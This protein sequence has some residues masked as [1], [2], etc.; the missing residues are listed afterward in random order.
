MTN[1]LTAAIKF[2]QPNITGFLPPLTLR[3]NR[4]DPQSLGEVSD[5]EIE[6]RLRELTKEINEIKKASPEKQLTRG[7]WLKLFERH[8]TAHCIQTASYVCSSL[9]ELEGNPEIAVLLPQRIIILVHDG[10]QLNLLSDVLEGKKEPSVLKL[11]HMFNAVNL[12]DRLKQE[13]YISR[14][15][16]PTFRELENLLGDTIAIDGTKESQ[17]QITTLASALRLLGDYTSDTSESTTLMLKPEN[18]KVKRILI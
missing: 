16:A 10:L 7:E 17:Y 2:L 14:I 6:T 13:D 18:E 3:I 15:S 8:N 1:T 5:T 11:R 12:P 4:D 9:K